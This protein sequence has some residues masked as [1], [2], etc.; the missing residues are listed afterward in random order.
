MRTVTKPWV[1]LAVSTALATAT[2][3]CGTVPVAK[4]PVRPPSAHA[5]PQVSV[6]RVQRLAF[7]SATSGWMAFSPPGAPATIEMAYT[8]NGGTTWTRTNRF[9]V[10]SPGGWTWVP[11][12]RRALLVVVSS[13][14]GTGSLQRVL[15]TTDRGQTWN[16]AQFYSPVGPGYVVAAKTGNRAACTLVVSGPGLGGVSAAL[17]CG[18]VAG[19]WH[20]VATGFG[21]SPNGYLPGLFPNGLTMTGRQAWITGQNVSNGPDLLYASHDAGQSFQPLSVPMPVATNADTWPVVVTAG[22]APALPVI[23]YPP[24]GAA[25][26]V[27]RETAHGTWHATTPLATRANPGPPGALLYSAVSPQIFFVRG[28]HTLYATTNGGTTWTSVYPSPNAWSVMQFATADQGWAVAAPAT[29]LH[30]S[31]GGRTWTTVRVRVYRPG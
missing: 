6:G 15:T 25:F 8:G 29:L 18:R 30:T 4:N 11:L 10:V 12:G 31:D 13:P 22:T 28:Q 7:T 21:T 19:G 27:Y 9:Q 1:A 26:V 14:S 2:A 5:R 16:T 24:T 23:T 17:Y 3:A 20:Q